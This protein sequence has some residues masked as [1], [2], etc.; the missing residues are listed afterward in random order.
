M[1]KGAWIVNTARGALCVAEDVAAALESGHIAGYAGDVWNQQVR[2]A[3][4]LSSHSSTDVPRSPHPRITAGGTCADL[5]GTGTAW[6]LTTLVRPP[7]PSFAR[8][9]LTSLGRRNDPGCPGSVCGWNEADP[10]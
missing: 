3:P 8:S 7:S 9:V 4:S 2:P 6:S 10:R 5:T 1:K